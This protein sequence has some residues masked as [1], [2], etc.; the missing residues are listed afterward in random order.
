MD[1]TTVR[2]ACLVGITSG[3]SELSFPVDENAPLADA[4]RFH[5]D[6]VCSMANRL[7]SDIRS[8]A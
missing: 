3:W 1:L 6:Q 7:L 4:A 5:L 8:P 2:A